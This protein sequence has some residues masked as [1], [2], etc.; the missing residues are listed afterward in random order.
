MALIEQKLKELDIK[1]DQFDR[2]G[3]GVLRTR[4][5]KDLLFIS[6][7]GPYDTFGIPLATGKVGTQITGE[8][9]YAAGRLTAISMLETIKDAIGDLDRIDYFVKGMVLFNSGGT[10]YDMPKYANGFSDLI[11]ALYGARGRHARAAM[12][13]GTHSDNVPIKVEM[14]VK[15]R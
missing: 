14:L 1:L 5:Y 4:R 7:H 10:F 9:G 8:E 15:L 12:G 13:C 11:V 3:K 6:A 2:K